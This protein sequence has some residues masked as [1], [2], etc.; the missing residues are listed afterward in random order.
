MLCIFA[1]TAS[2][3][4]NFIVDIIPGCNCIQ[5]LDMLLR[6]RWLQVDPDV[7]HLVLLQMINT[8]DLEI[9]IKLTS[10]LKFLP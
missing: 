2:A 10:H 6:L 1:R 7:K 5:F 9:M 3:I 8:P 4:V